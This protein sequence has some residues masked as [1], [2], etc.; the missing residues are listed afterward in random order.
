[1][2]LA[3][4]AGAL[5]ATF[6]T[7]LA[8]NFVSGEKRIERKLEHRHAVTH[9]QF[10]RELGTLLGPPILG[11]NLVANLENGAQIFPAMLDAIRQAQKTVNFETYI[12]WSGDIGREFVAALTERARAGVEVQVLMDWVG[13][14]KMDPALL[15]E[16]EVAGVTVERYHPLK[17]YHLAR[18]NNRTH[19][20]LLVVDGRIGFTGGVG[21]AD[22]WDGNA[23]SPDHWRDSHYRIE[24]PA[25]AQ[26]QAAF[27]DNWIK[28]T[29]AVLQGDGYFPAVAGAGSADAQVFTASPN[30]GG[31]SMLLMYLLAITAAETSIDLSAAYFVPDELTR[32]A[33]VAAIRRGVRL[34]VIVPG[35]RID[36]EVVRKASRASWGELLEAGAEI[37]EYQPTM[38]HCKTLIVDRQLVSVGSTN[39][40]NRSFRLNDEANLN[41]YDPEFA[42]RVTA[43][44]EQDLERSRRITLEAWK[45]RPWHEK[46][47]EKASA[48]LSSQL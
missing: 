13:S 11:G 19:R 37:H 36:A 5:L 23:D 26:M 29:G 2:W 47:V 20:K 33:L 42:A 14:Q 9:P 45:N 24:G 46:L 7:V 1:M 41:V 15:E 6:L 25:V 40:D 17:W 18:M 28:T 3:A 32:A 48:L 44:F 4:V 22:N 21:I 34:R 39:F 35:T 8:L 38:F 31:D 27:L 30:G 43:V 16:L 12:Y 10:R